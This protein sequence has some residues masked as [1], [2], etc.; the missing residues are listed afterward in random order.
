MIEVD[1]LIAIVLM[2]LLFLRH[3]NVYKDRNKI[4]YTPV[5]V[6][7]G[8]IAGLLHFV[9]MSDSAGWLLALRESLL[10]VIIGVIFSAIMSV[11]SQT[12]NAANQYTD[13][14]RLQNIADDIELLKTLFNKVDGQLG[15]VAQMEDST[16]VQ[17][18]SIFKE[19]ID[20]LNIIQSNQ[21]LFIQKIEFI[22]TKQQDSMEKFEEFTL[23]EL[24]SLDNIVHRHID[25]LRISEQDHFNQLKNAAKVSL[26]NKE[27]INEE[28]MHIK[29]LLEKVYQSQSMESV[30]AQMEEEF[31]RIIHEFSRHIQTIGS[32]SESIVT[33]LLENEKIL[34]G[35]RE[36]SEL[37]MQQMVLSSNHM[38]EMS[39]NSKE[40]N[41]SIKPLGDLFGSAQSLHKEFML[42]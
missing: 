8:I 7:I 25:L 35:S 9:M 17:L 12:Q 15:Q 13:I 40:L 34:K 18:K 21:K 10:T 42:A 19:E 16:H 11:M 36:Q 31:S 5:V 30:I 41:E 1:L 32:K 24:P 4:N 23:N 14:L 6:G 3:I 39:L 22:L 33:T 28:L 37:I 27:E 29:I 38:R 26:E 20:S 2:S